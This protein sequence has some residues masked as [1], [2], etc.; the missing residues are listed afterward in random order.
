MTAFAFQQLDRG[1]ARYT[2]RDRVLTLEVEASVRPIGLIV[3]LS[4]AKGWDDSG[5]PMTEADRRR[6]K[7]NLTSLDTSPFAKLDIC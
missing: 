2:E 1:T 7:A 3:Y 5:E 6:I 4:A